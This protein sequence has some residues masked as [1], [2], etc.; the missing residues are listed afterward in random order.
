MHN[1]SEGYYDETE[2]YRRQ[3]QAELNA[4][5]AERAALGQ[6]YGQVWSTDELRADFEV[7]GFMAPYVVV[8]CR[9][10]KQK[11]SLEFQGSPRYYFLFKNDTK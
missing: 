5:A 3:R 6:E 1:E 11:G 4:A 7:L 8:R 9:A 2:A 10:D